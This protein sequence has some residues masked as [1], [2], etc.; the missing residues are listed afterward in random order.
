MKRR[1]PALALYEGVEI[2]ECDWLI[3][4]IVRNHFR[5]PSPAVHARNATAMMKAESEGL[6]L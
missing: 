6:R 5:A 1:R 4:G 3:C 2:A